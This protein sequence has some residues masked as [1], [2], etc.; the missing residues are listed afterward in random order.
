MTR[1]RKTRKETGEGLNAF[2]LRIGMEPA[3]LSWIERGKRP[4]RRNA[5]KIAKGLDTDPRTIWPDF[6]AFRRW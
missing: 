5:L 3:L 4:C 1:L 6:D 2:A